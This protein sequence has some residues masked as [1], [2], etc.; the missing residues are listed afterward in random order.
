MVSPPRSA[1]FTAVSTLMRYARL[2]KVT[3]LLPLLISVFNPFSTRSH[4]CAAMNNP[5]IG[6]TTGHGIGRY[7]NL[8]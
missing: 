8:Q 7:S 5:I 3:G 6:S 2:F 4:V 1:D